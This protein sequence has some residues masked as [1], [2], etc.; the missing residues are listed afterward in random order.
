MQSL[1][2]DVAG[3]LNRSLS[4]YKVKV[5]DLVKEIPFGKFQILMIITFHF[6]YSSPSIVVYN[7]AFFLMYPHY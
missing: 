3:S 2:L 7:Y 4:R 5:D 6:I 1:E